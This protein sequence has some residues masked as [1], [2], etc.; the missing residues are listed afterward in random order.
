MIIWV[1]LFLSCLFVANITS[2]SDS[3]R[4]DKGLLILIFYAKIA[5]FSWNKHLSHIFFETWGLKFRKSHIRH[6]PS[7]LIH[8]PSSIFHLTSS[9][10]HLTSSI[11]HHPSYIRLQPSAIFHLPSSIFIIRRI[12]TTFVALFSLMLFMSIFVSHKSYK[13][14]EIQHSKMYF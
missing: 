2:F 6:H 4:G 3:T 1:W 14:R 13:I 10:F 8:H 12:E 11:L 5:F 9:F 7:A